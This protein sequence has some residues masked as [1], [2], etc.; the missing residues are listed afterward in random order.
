M[1]F[2]FVFVAAGWA[3]LG[4]AYAVQARVHKLKHQEPYSSFDRDGTIAGTYIFWPVSWVF[5]LCIWVGRRMCAK[6]DVIAEKIVN[7]KETPQMLLRA[8]DGPDEG[9]E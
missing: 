6:A 3:V 2:L 9:E 4:F 1:V 7:G 8:T 5:W